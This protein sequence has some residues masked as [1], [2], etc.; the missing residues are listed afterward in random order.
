MN[1]KRERKKSVMNES[2]FLASVD[3]ALKLNFFLFICCL[4][5]VVATC[6][7]ERMAD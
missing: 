3:T 7:E 2:V 1:Q 4:F 6:L 5:T